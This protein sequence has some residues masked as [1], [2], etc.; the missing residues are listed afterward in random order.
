MKLAGLVIALHVTVLA[1]VQT[2]EVRGRGGVI[3]ERNP[4]DMKT[5][6][7]PCVYIGKYFTI[8]VREVAEEI[9]YACSLLANATIHIRT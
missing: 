1:T 8:D 4:G 9:K 5:E 6:D 3:D 7:N 2:L